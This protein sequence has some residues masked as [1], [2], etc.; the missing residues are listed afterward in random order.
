[1]QNKQS[2]CLEYLNKNLSLIAALLAFLVILLG[3]SVRLQH[4]GLGCPDW[5]GC[6]GQLIVPEEYI[7]NKVFPELPFDAARA[8][9]E[10]THRYAAG[11]LLL[12][13]LVIVGFTIKNRNTPAQPLVLPFMAFLLGIFQALLGM[14]TVTLKLHPFI[15][16]THLTGGFLILNLLWLTW[17]KQTRF[18]QKQKSSLK[19]KRLRGWGL[20]C[21]AVLSVQILLGG[22]MSAN[23]ASLAC[24]DFPRCQGE[25]WPAMNFREGFTLWHDFGHNYEFG[26]LTNPARVALHMM[27]RVGALITASALAIFAITAVIRT[28]PEVNRPA[29]LLLLLLT[30]QAGLGIWNVL[31][32]LPLWNA[33]L[34]NGVAALLT[35]TL[36]SINW[37][38]RADAP[39][40]LTREN[41]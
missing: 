5:P 31:G 41:L 15:V 21:L 12:T 10:M 24:A 17:C 8:W 18:L 16:M 13:L 39:D 30:L 34:H 26:V 3:A 37:A 28:R 20:F 23:Y 35:V 29:I 38:L 9:I 27:H 19:E 14:W 32:S 4:A 33:V 7:V 40:V 25:W 1:M 22:W 6:Y 36:V 2:P 11:F